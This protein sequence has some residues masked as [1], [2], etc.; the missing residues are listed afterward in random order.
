MLAP[1]HPLRKAIDEDVNSLR[2]ANFPDTK[3][4]VTGCFVEVADSSIWV[5]QHASYVMASKVYYRNIK[6]SVNLTYLPPL[7]QTCRTGRNHHLLEPFFCDNIALQVAWSDHPDLLQELDGVPADVTEGIFAAR[8]VSTLSGLDFDENTWT[9]RLVGA[10]KRHLP[11]H[12]AKYTADDATRFRIVQSQYSLLG[13]SSDV[14]ECYIFRGCT[15]IRI[16]KTIVVDVEDD[17]PSSGDD[18]KIELGKK[19]D[20]LSAYPPKLGQLVA[21]CHITILQKCA[22][23][24]IKGKPIILEV[25]VCT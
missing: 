17:P 16:G 13:T 5:Y 23:M 4:S 3:W 19:G 22:R 9:K 11:K 24:F 1:S 7:L 21:A 10:L 15:D 20:P 2:R 8:G 25:L 6:A 18:T 12:D 14:V